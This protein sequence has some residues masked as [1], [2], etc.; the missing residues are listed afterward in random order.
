MKLAPVVDFGPKVTHE[1]FFRVISL[2]NW[3]K[4]GSEGSNF[5]FLEKRVLGRSA[6]QEWFRTYLKAPKRPSWPHDCP[7]QISKA[8]V[9]Q[10]PRYGPQRPRHGPINAGFLN[11]KVSQKKFTC[12]ILGQFPPFS[13]VLVNGT[14][15]IAEKR[16]SEDLDFSSI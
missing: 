13:S 11:L 14:L 8:Y 6:E 3:V 9:K 5:G 10:R 7:R 2:K 4:W 16:P 1:P 15:V 12:Q